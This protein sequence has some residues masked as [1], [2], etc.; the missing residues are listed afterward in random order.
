MVKKNAPR[1][2]VVIFRRDFRLAGNPAWSR[3]SKWCEE[4]GASVAPCF[5]FSDA[6]IDRDKNP[7]YSDKAYAA[8]RRCL[9]ALDAE[10]GHRLSYFRAGR[11][12]EAL[13]YIADRFDVGAVFF[14]SDVTPF[15]TRRDDEIAAWCASAGVLC[16]RGEPG[17]GYTVWPV[18]SV[19]TGSQTVPKSFSAFYGYTRDRAIP[20]TSRARKARILPRISAV[21]ASVPE[22]G[23]LEEFPSLREVVKRLRAGEHDGYGETR[24]DY[25]VP[26]TR[27]SVHLKF[28]RLDPREVLRVARKIPALERQLVWRE[29]YY[30]L[31]WGYPE[32]LTVPNRHIRPDRQKVDWTPSDPGKVEAWRTGT[33]G[34]PLVDLAMKR[35][36]KTGY[37][38]NRLRMVVASY[39][40]KDMGMDWRDGERLMAT[41]L[42]DY[43]PA[44]NSGGWQSMD[45]QLKGQAIKA[46]TQARKFGLGL[47]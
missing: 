37:L 39:F 23:P 41:M 22:P 13:R 1:I 43:D 44:Q 6:Q 12:A 9:D 14:N 28:G 36:A 10:L 40:T 32:I 3:C 17:E 7:Y 4:T 47:Q 5:V 25:G 45:A 31:A 2:A 34:E 30:H 16:D 19:M 38:H 42:V 26:T 24:D 27:L 21:P 15:A 33:T 8:M 29:F 46:S 11:D 20:A 35:L 18:G